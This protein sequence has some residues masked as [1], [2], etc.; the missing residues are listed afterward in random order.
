VVIETAGTVRV[1]K[2]FTP[3]QLDAAIGLA[4]SGAA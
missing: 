4:V 2:P 3:E 1:G